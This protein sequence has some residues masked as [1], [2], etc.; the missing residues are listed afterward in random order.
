M[1]ARSGRTEPGFLAVSVVSLLIVASPLVL[2][3]SRWRL[4]A[5]GAA[6]AALG[7]VMILS[8]FSFA[9]AILPFALLMLLGAVQGARARPGVSGGWL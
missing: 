9:P 8:G 1:V 7:V 4:F 5:E 2:W 6:V 3:K